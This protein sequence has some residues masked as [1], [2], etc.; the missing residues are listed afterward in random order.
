M[1]GVRGFQLAF[2]V[3]AT[4]FV[5]SSQCLYPLFRSLAPYSDQCRVMP[6]PIRVT[7]AACRRTFIDPVIVSLYAVKTEFAKGFHGRSFTHAVGVKR[8]RPTSRLIALAILNL[9]AVPLSHPKALRTICPDCIHRGS[10][11]CNVADG[12]QVVPRFLNLFSHSFRG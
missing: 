6:E 10:L 8:T 1:K 9:V 12:R 4:P 2:Y 3:V 5:V 7:R 11:C